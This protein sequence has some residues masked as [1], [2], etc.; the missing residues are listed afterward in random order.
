MALQKINN[1]IAGFT[2]N[3]PSNGQATQAINGA[4]TWCAFS[5]Q[6]KSANLNEIHIFVYSVTGTVVAADITCDIYSDSSGVPNSSIESKNCSTSLSA[7]G[8]YK[9]TG[10][11]STYT[12]GTQYWAVFKNVN[13]TPASNYVTFRFA[14]NGCYLNAITGSNPSYGW[15]KRLWNG[16]NWT[17]SNATSAPGI[18]IVYDTSTVAQYDGV[19]LNVI[20]TEST[21]KTYSNLEVGVKFT[22]P[23]NGKFRVIGATFFIFRNGTPTGNLRYRLYNG[24]S[25]VDTTVSTVG[26][27]NTGNGVAQWISLF[28]SSTNVLDSNTVYRLTISESTQSDSSSN[29]YSTYAYTVGTDTGYSSLLPFNG[30]LQKTAYNGSS[31]TD[32]SSIIY[33]FGLILENEQALDAAAS[34]GG[35]HS[36]GFFG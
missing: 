25:L 26:N 27:G 24:T 33:P 30:T 14:S 3:A 18:I 28:F 1:L 17:T 23:T 7:Q 5:F 36:I 34:S 4:S 35:A 15:H 19:A 22:T 13:G 20:T 16:T 32:T 29:Y 31:W 11:T 6:A 8:F 9:W 12:V 2:P 10:F 21:D